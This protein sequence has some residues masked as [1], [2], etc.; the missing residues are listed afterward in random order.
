VVDGEKE[1]ERVREAIGYLS[2]EGKE[3][4][5]SAREDQWRGVV[6][7]GV[8]SVA[9]L[10]IPAVTIITKK[11]AVSFP[12]DRRTDRQTDRLDGQTAQLGP[13]HHRTSS[14]IPSKKYLVKK[15]GRCVAALDGS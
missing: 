13:L 15:K 8:V 1:E 6:W 2:W 7:C 4:M 5:I 3:M 12:S 11:W 10:A 14:S 9:E